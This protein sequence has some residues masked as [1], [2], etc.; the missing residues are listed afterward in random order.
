ME[1]ICGCPVIISAALA[2]LLPKSHAAMLDDLDSSHCMK[3]IGRAVMILYS[4][5]ARSRQRACSM[6]SSA[7]VRKPIMCT[8]YRK[9]YHLRLKSAVCFP[10]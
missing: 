5:R 4:I 6:I 1:Y 9:W 3:Y 7:G 8:T 10:S 2:Y